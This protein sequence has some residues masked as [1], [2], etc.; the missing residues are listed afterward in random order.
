MFSM[1]DTSK[2]YAQKSVLV[3]C[4]LLAQPATDVDF[5]FRC[6]YNLSVAASVDREVGVAYEVLTLHLRNGGAYNLT[7][8]YPIHNVF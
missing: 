3:H 8:T 7:S 2:H 1:P 6:R 4:K 5:E